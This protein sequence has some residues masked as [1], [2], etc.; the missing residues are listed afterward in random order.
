[1]ADVS[2]LNGYD[3]K[4]TV[5][6]QEVENLRQEINNMEP[7]E[8]DT[9]ELVTKEYFNDFLESLEEILVDERESNSAFEGV[10][11]FSIA[12]GTVQK[13]E[14]GN[15]TYYRIP[16]IT[17]SAKNTIIA[18]TDAR[19]DTAADNSG[20][21]S[22]YCRRSTDKGVTWGPAIE[23]CKFPTNEDGTQTSA[24]AR[25]MDSTVIASKSGKLFCLNGAWKSNSGNWSQ[26]ASTPDPDWLFKLSVSEDDGLNWTTYD[27]NNLPNMLIGMPND[28]VSALGGVGQGIQMYDGTL[29]FPVQ[30]TRRP[31]GVRTVCATIIYSKD[32]GATWTMAPNFA[33]AG[34]GENNIVEIAPGKI[35]MNARGGNA[36]P[37]F[38][39]ED[40]GKT[41]K[42]H[43]MS[44]KIGNG[45]VGCQ[46]SSS[47]IDIN[48]K[49]VFLHSSPINRNS[50]Y[51]R[52]S[53]TLY[54]SYDWENYDQI[55]TYYPTAGD[56]AGAG[57]SCLA[58]AEIDGQL[59]LFALY[60]RQ[61]NIA[62]RNLGLDLEDIAKRSKDYFALPEKKFESSK[63]DLMKL[64]EKFSSSELVLF[65]MLD[66]Y[67]NNMSNAERSLLE[68]Q[69]VKLCGMDANGEVIDRGTTKWQVNGNVLVSGNVYYFKEPSANNWI[70]TQQ[71]RLTTDY[72]VDFDVFVKGTTDTNWNFLFSLDNLQ[73]PGCG[74]A[75]NSNN[76]WNPAFDFNGS[77]TYLEPSGDF[78]GRWI[79]ITLTKSSVE[80]AK[81]Y[82]DGVLTFTKPSATQSTKDYQ[83]FT[84]GNNG[85]SAKKFHGKIANFKVFN[86]IAN[87]EEVAFLYEN[88]RKGDQFTIEL[89]K[90]V[91]KIPELLQDV[92][93]CNLAGHKLDEFEEAMPH[94]I[95]SNET[96]WDMKGNVEYKIR[97]NSFMFDGNSTNA[98]KTANFLDVN[99]TVDFDVFID[100][101]PN[102]NWTQLF[103]I[104]NSD[105]T[106]GFSLAIDGA[107]TWNPLVDGDGSKT[108]TDPNESFVGKW[109]H[110]TLTKDS[111]NGYSVYHDGVL[112]WNSQTD[113]TLQGT[114]SVSGYS[115]M[116]IGNNTA[117]EKQFSGEIANF[118]IYDKVLSIEEIQEIMVGYAGTIVRENYTPNGAS[119]TDTVEADFGR[120]EIVATFNLDTCTRTNGENVLSFGSNIKSWSGNK[121]HFYYYA[122]TD[123][124]LVQ[125]MNGS[126]YQNIE[127]YV[128]GNVTV[129]LSK[130]GLTINDTLYAASNYVAIQN[131]TN[132]TTIE[133]GSA[134]G[135]GRSNASNYSIKIK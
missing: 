78:I 40:M 14:G 105:G 94:D 102:T 45:S 114:S 12:D 38:I 63:S 37:T 107:N 56:G 24:R 77:S 91:S 35:L 5:A 126:S 54:A 111:T 59:C 19:F 109:I 39:T 65:N 82:H 33:P 30:L 120:Q 79:H 80:G 133:V 110:L 96:V 21:I 76:T 6:R 131:V 123:R 71:L 61:G 48:G 97:Q 62:F 50:N 119:F 100:K 86:K 98:L 57:Y 135:A 18:F 85:A 1:M 81:I 116:T 34:D 41:W 58:P 8:I 112:A 125:C 23:V 55:R 2:K 115:I 127:V 25:S 3:I 60:E 92:V 42:S 74:L 49:D 75:I 20:R 88:R 69:V 27:L 72:T 117:L 129:R 68:T 51:T 101:E 10:D 13:P 67:L 29:V 15:A 43:S 46:G 73:V 104:G 28:I 132:L 66:N 70:R 31:N 122:D 52:D 36:R 106:Q 47:K 17:V 83:N 108:Y 53:I 128:T 99:F 87:D 113:A 16:A 11:I 103:C 44:G 9:S 84:I 89:S 90:Y 95:G 4:D 124:L 26:V 22:I 32:D 121:L 7:P 130:E 93:L 134:E 64:L 118:K